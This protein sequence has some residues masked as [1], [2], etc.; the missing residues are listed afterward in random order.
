MVS[1]LATLEHRKS[2][3]HALTLDHLFIYHMRMSNAHEQRLAAE[4][5]SEHGGARRESAQVEKA[6]EGEATGGDNNRSKK[7]QA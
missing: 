6:A 5:R 1:R 7:Q 2:Q 3:M 4:M